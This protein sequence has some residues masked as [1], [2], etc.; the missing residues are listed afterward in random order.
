MTPDQYYGLMQ[1]I[2]ESAVP[3]YVHIYMIRY[4]NVHLIVLTYTTLTV[5]PLSPHS[6][7]L[8]CVT[9]DIYES[10]HPGRNYY[11]DLVGIHLALGLGVR[12]G[13]AVAIA[14]IT[15]KKEYEISVLSQKPSVHFFKLLVCISLTVT[16]LLL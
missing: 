1:D 7:L 11:T 13:D 6:F 12:Y 5:H 4:P 10:N 15:P 2:K 9:Q 16:K 8:S 14:Y 3:F